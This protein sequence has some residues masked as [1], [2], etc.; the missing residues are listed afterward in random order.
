M[1]PGLIAGGASRLHPVAR[2][3]RHHLLHLGTGDGDLSGQGLFAGPPRVSPDINAAS[4]VLIVI[5]LVAT[6][7]AMRLQRSKGIDPVTS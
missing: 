7:L 5:T 6:V 2:R 3:F 1:Q 4:T